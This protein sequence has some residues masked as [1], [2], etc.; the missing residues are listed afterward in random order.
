MQYPGDAVDPY[1]EFR[2]F[3]SGRSLRGRIL[4]T[5][6]S[7]GMTALAYA[8]HRFIYKRGAVATLYLC[9]EQEPTATSSLRLGGTKDR[10][11]IPRLA[12]NWELTGRTWDTVVEFA[13]VVRSEIRR[14]GVGE[15]VLREEILAGKR[16]D[17][18]LHDIGH[19]MGGTAFGTVES[20]SV[21]DVDLRLRGLAN[22]WVCS[23]S[24]FPTGSHSNPTLTV[25][26]LADRLIKQLQ[27]TSGSQS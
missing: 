10:F 7:Y 12:V 20:E 26:A 17:D 23:A 14:L 13:A 19:H 21:V 22:A 25:L 5:A 9:A 18:L 27:P 16:R 2:N 1:A 4:S 24:V 3:V 8:R 6:R 15:V 11:G